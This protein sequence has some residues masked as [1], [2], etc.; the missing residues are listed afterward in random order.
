M[1][2]FSTIAN[3]GGK[4]SNNSTDVKQFVLSPQSGVV[5]WVLK[6]IN[7]TTSKFITP[8]IDNNVY[9]N[10]L[11]ADTITVTNFNNISD[12]SL[13]ENIFNIEK[14]EYDKIL[15]VVPKKYNF[16]NDENKK[17]HFGLIAQEFES[18]FPELVNCKESDNIKTINYLELIPILIGKIHDLQEQINELKEKI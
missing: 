6:N 7:N 14:S 1:S 16:I 10:N 12:V 2:V 4:L 15:N 9:I 8:S 17:L 11:T 18:F 3:Y 13:K 5:D